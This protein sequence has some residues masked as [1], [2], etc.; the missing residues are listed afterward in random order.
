[1]STSQGVRFQLVM[2]SDSIARAAPMPSNTAPKAS[3]ARM[4]HM[5]MQEILRVLRMVSSITLR[6][7]RLR[8]QGGHRGGG[9]ADRGA[10]HQA[11]DA[12]DEQAGHEKENQERGDAGAQ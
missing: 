3:A 2:N 9:R 4:T 1:M 5:N 11:G 7:R 12:H 10:F 6:F 8:E